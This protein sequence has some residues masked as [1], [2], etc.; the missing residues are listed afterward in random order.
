[1]HIMKDAHK[2][3]NNE[4]IIHTILTSLLM[5]LPGN[6]FQFYGKGYLAMDAVDFRNTIS[7]PVMRIIYI[8]FILL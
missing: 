3:R 5:T 2:A 4:T 6:D 7:V 1:M 8:Y